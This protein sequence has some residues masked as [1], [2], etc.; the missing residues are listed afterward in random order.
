VDA[1]GR[2]ALLQNVSIGSPLTELG[3][4]GSYPSPGLGK[5]SNMLWKVARKWEHILIGF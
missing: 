1:G 5:P 3:G 2:A 4:N